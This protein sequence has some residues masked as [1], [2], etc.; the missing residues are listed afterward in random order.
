MHKSYDL[1]VIGTGSA[2]T[3]VALTCRA[4]GWTVAVIDSL[5]FGGTCVLRGCDPKKV[6]VGA[7]EL[8]DW[9]RR[10]RGKGVLAPGARITWPD[11]MRFKR[12]FSAPAS[13]ARED[14]F[15]KAGVESFHGHAAFTGP[16]SVAVDGETLEA[17]FVVIASGAHPAP[18]GIPGEALLT[19]SDVFLDLD[20]LPQYIAFVGGGYI[21]FEFAHL[22]ARAGSQATI[23]HG[24][25][26]P[27]EHFDPGLVSRLVEHSRSL[28]ID[29][30]L[31]TP[32]D[33][34]EGE[35]GSIRVHSG[36]R[37]FDTQ[38]VVHAAGRRP[39][40][41]G[42]NLAAAG[43]ESDKNGVKVNEFLRSVSNP[44]VY[45]AGDAAAGGG[46][47][48]TPVAGYQGRIVAA[49]LLHGDRH[50]PNYAGMASAVFTIPPL[51]MVG[52]GEE[53]ARAQGLRFAVH[54]GDAGHWYSSRRVNEPCAGFKVLV[55]E[56]T[57]RIL[58]A[59]LLH[60]QAAEHINLFAL[61]VRFGLRGSDIK[62]TLFA[63]PTHASD[64]QYMLE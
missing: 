6:L 60:D 2:A 34:I 53:S 41:D 22:A 57:G 56:G 18:L 52:L 39:D 5:P 42:L 63:Y 32:V 20:Y 35:P 43:V 62:D 14:T 50:T 48:L 40:L 9:L 51:A 47:P 27:L 21:A 36:V 25:S 29:V 59:H 58:G 55:E 38:M 17:R 26:R 16:R 37:H 12:T 3:T 19:H 49:N 33:A 7:A 45:A 64:T 24:N 23:L 31:E 54:Q 30:Q 10:M 11:L 4:A 8:T 13:Q 1:V 28:G 44:S 61:A 46:A 15:A